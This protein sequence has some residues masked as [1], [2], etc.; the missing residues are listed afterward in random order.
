MQCLLKTWTKGGAVNPARAKIQEQTLRNFCSRLVPTF[1]GVPT[2]GPIDNCTANSAHSHESGDFDDSAS[3]PPPPTKTKRSRGGEG[4]SQD[5]CADKFSSIM[6]SLKGDSLGRSMFYDVM[7]EF[8]TSRG[9]HCASHAPGAP[10][11]ERTRGRG[12]SRKGART[13]GKKRKRGDDVH[14]HNKHSKTSNPREN[15][16]SKRLKSGTSV[17]PE[18][19]TTREGWSGDPAQIHLNKFGGKVGYVV[20]CYPPPAAAAQG[21]W[22][23]RIEDGLTYTDSNGDVFIKLCRWFKINSFTEIDKNYAAEPC[24]IDSVKAYG[25]PSFF[26]TKKQ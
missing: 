11:T 12:D 6:H 3:A 14:K 1:E 19:E 8:Q 22:F 15:A 13:K 20:E 21:R 2:A 25:P 17:A 9:R 4:R 16:K 5:E 10:E 7:C 26:S 23:A 18:P 24:D